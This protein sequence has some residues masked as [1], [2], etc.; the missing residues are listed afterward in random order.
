MNFRPLHLGFALLLTTL[1]SACYK[2]PVSEPMPEYTR[3]LTSGRWHVVAD[4][5]M[6]TQ[7]DGNHTITDNFVQYQ[8]CQQDD[9]WMFL[10]ADQFAVNR[11]IMKCQT[12]EA[13]LETG[14]WYFSDDR[15]RLLVTNPYIAPGLVPYEILKLTDTELKLQSDYAI[16]GRSYS[17]LILL[18]AL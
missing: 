4:Q 10:D 17:H 11:G 16:N 3:L 6:E 15:H 13:E 9:Y 1:L 8:E 14:K 5:L 12:T 2:D 18:E 7:P